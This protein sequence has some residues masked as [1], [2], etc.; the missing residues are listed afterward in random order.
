M[1]A[2]CIL[3]NAIT[4]KRTYYLLSLIVWTGLTSIVFLV[5]YEYLNVL[6]LIDDSYQVAT[7]RRSYTVCKKVHVRRCSHDFFRSGLSLQSSQARLKISM[8]SSGQGATF[9]RR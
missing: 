9:G 3:D 7:E 2:V 1:T 6:V 5:M 4:E 8:K